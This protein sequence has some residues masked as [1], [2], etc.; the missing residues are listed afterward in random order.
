MGRPKKINPC[1]DKGL[2]FMGTSPGRTYNVSES[3]TNNTL[4]YSG[5]E[6]CSGWASCAG[7]KKTFAWMHYVLD[8]KPINEPNKNE[9]Q[10]H[11]LSEFEDINEE[12][13]IL[14]TPCNESFRYPD[15]EHTKLYRKL[16]TRQGHHPKKIFSGCQNIEEELTVN[17][18]IRIR[19]PANETLGH[20]MDAV[21]QHLKT[22]EK[23]DYLNLDQS[24]PLSTDEEDARE[25]DEHSLRFRKFLKSLTPKQ[26]KALKL[27]YLENFDDLSRTD[28][29]ARLKIKP[30]SLD[31]RLSGAKKK[32]L[33]HFPELAALNRTVIPSSHRPNSAPLYP[34]TFKN[35]KTGESRTLHPK[36]RN[37]CLLGPHKEKNIEDRKYIK[38]QL[39]TEYLENLKFEY[40]AFRSPHFEPEL[41]ELSMDDKID[42]IVKKAE[43]T[44]QAI[45]ASAKR[46]APTLQEA[47]ALVMERVISI[48]KSLKSVKE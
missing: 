45:A 28:I 26:R 27:T 24:N 38:A 12:R 30:D 19:L 13:E 25:D 7:E 42:V 20:L 4:V 35:I 44:A 18:L 33:K 11:F 40:S 46:G 23:G 43:E 6:L 9:P 14:A 8:V 16:L 15:S 2:D 47:S 22:Y 31:E 32:L 10:G 48:M 41:K 36:S 37:D 1:Q 34:C 17:K 21:L 5:C 3:G 39:R 29:A